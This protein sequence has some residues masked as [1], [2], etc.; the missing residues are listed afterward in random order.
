MNPE[1]LKE[2]QH[3]IE[4]AERKGFE[5]VRGTPNTLLLDLDTKA[6]REHFDNAWK[7]LRSFLAVKITRRWPSKSGKGEHIEILLPEEL[8]VVERLL[9]QACLGSDR[10]HEMLSL[11]TGVWNGNDSPTVLFKPG[12]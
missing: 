11:C 9:I 5:I 10:L 7:C 1:Y 12:V 8:P 2:F 6:D 3:A 4:V